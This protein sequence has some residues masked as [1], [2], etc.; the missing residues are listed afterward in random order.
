[1]PSYAVTRDGK[2]IVA[3]CLTENEWQALKDSYQ[4]GDLLMPCCKT[5]AIPKTSPNFL[6]FFAHLS[7][8]CASSP[9]S[10]WHL[11]TKAVLLRELL[12]FGIIAQLEKIGRSGSSAWKADVF[13]T[14]A[15]RQIAIEIQHSYQ[16]LRDYLGRQERYA[17]S[18]VEAYWLLYP[19]RYMT[20]AKSIGKYRIK[21]E[22]GGKF[23]AEGIIFPCIPQLPIAWFDPLDESGMVK[24]AKFLR[25]NMH[26]WLKSLIQ[27]K[28]LYDAGTW[29]IG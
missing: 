25:I 19:P 13:F 12:S 6:Q 27:R 28:F 3:E 26:D 10:L 5:A 24:G 8:E 7:D 9:E 4:I 20:L 1:M 14:V 15:D 11:E 22:F 16:H 23:P 17:Q 2:A 18:G 29:R 21:T